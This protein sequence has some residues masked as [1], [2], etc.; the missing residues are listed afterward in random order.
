MAPWER[1][2]RRAIARAQRYP[3]GADGATGDVVVQFTVSA[4]GALSGLRVIA[5]SGNGVLD[6]AALETIGRAAPFPPLPSGSGLSSK[7]VQLPLGF[8]RD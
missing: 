7:L 4:S 6:Q 1:Q 2:V 5:S 3:R 8:V